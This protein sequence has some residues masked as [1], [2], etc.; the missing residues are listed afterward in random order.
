MKRWNGWAN[1][2]ITYEVPRSDRENLGEIPGSL[3]SLGGTIPHQYGV[4]TDHVPFLPAE[5]GIL[6]MDAIRSICKSFDP[7]GMMNSGKLF[8]G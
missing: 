2:V 5:K 6:G 7:D 8:A 1:D 4:G 3:Q